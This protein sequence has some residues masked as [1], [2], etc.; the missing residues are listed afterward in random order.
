M[1]LAGCVLDLKDHR[2]EIVKKGKSTKPGT[3]IFP[4]DD[5]DERHVKKL[6]A[7]I[8][9]GNKLAVTEL[10]NRYRSQ[11][12]SV[13]YTMVNAYDEAADLTQIVFAPRAQIRWRYD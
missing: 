5:K 13:A 3:A 4:A 10:V 2:L 8:K 7:D 11:V 9:R 6:V 1:L 12:A